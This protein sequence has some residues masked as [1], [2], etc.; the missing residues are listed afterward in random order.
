MAGG[1]PAAAAGR[2]GGSGQRVESRVGT[3]R[4]GSGRVSGPGRVGYWAWAWA[5]RK[6]REGGW[7]EFLHCSPVLF[8][9]GISPLLLGGSVS[10]L[11]FAPVSV[12][13]S[14]SVGKIK[15]TGA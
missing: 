1:G 12:N 10:P 2:V 14:R 6:R 7:C 3:G 11:V 8:I 15:V 4:V 5:E 9:G 13:F